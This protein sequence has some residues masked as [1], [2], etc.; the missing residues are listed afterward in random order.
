MNTPIHD[1]LTKYSESFP[2]RCHMPGDKGLKEPLDITEI[3]GADSLYEAGGIISESEENAARLYGSGAVCYSCGGST[4]SINTM[5]SMASLLTRKDTIVAGR[6]SHRSLIDSCIMLG[7]KV[8]WVYPEEYLSADIAPE[9]IERAIDENTAAVFI[10]SIDYYG[11][12][13]DI[14]SIGEI[15]RKKGVLLLVD[16]AHGAYRVFTET[17]PITLGADMCA[18]SA[19]KTMPCI[20]GSA[21]LHLKNK[22]HKP[23]AK[24]AMALFG[25]SSPSYLMLDS[26]DL[27]NRFI[28]EEKESAEKRLRAISYLKERISLKG[29][30][31]ENSDEMRITIDANRL[32]YSGLDFAE[33]LRKSGIECEMSDDRYVV[34]L[35]SVVQPMEDF[36]RIFEALTGMRKKLAIVPKEREIIKPRSVI[37]PRKAFFSITETIKT[38]SSLGKVCAAVT[39]PCPPCIPVVMPGEVITTEIINALKNYGVKEIRV[40]M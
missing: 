14:R 35:F 20:T 33:E 4:L 30:M 25:S 3:K 12:D 1:F 27:C 8:K 36:D 19:H 40:V 18:D 24:E 34:L 7:L 16:N 6:Y 13:A 11:G 5:L 22:E 32:G 38:E 21:L 9:E 39:C 10:N 15:C 29:I 26:L 31:V 2:L 28:E 17:H 23:L 37:A